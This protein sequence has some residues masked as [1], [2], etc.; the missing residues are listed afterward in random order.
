M[1][2]KRH[3]K[4]VPVLVCVTTLGLAMGLGVAAAQQDDPP[5]SD[6]LP[7]TRLSPEDID[8]LSA[9]DDAIPLN[10]AGKRSD[11]GPGVPAQ[12]AAE[13]VLK[14]AGPDL[15][16]T[17]IEV[18][19]APESALDPTLPWI[20]VYIDGSSITNGGDVA[21]TWKASLIQ[22]AMTDLMYSEQTAANQ[23]IGGSRIIV[24]DSSGAVEYLD[25]G[26]GF[27]AT[28]QIF[29]AQA[30]GRGMAAIKDGVS[31]ALRLFDLRLDSLEVFQ[32][33]GPAVSMVLTLLDG[34]EM[35]WTIDQLRQAIGGVAYEGILI[36]I[37]D[38][39]G[40]PVLV[41]GV[42]YRTGLGGVWFADGY[43]E[44]LGVAHGGNPLV[45]PQ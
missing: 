25:G 14:A 22:G 28:G 45:Q 36:T 18:T 35:D 21:L 10:Y 12:T 42:S 39:Q 41:S 27:V 20:D 3:W 23:V 34:A 5:S 7:E 1:S 8:R 44:K 19:K 43:D 2:P 17:R 38:S 15:G 31:S 6:T 4:L 13:L 32:P 37:R 40:A 9:P 33:E 16:V 24:E 26:G 29:A 30:D 11:R